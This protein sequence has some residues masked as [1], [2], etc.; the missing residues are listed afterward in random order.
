MA[1]EE[2]MRESTFPSDLKKCWYR[3]RP[4]LPLFTSSLIVIC[5]PAYLSQ[6]MPT[7][8]EM[9]DDKTMHQSIPSQGPPTP[10]HSFLPVVHRARAS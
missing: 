4:W 8:P 9:T 10:K 3:L 1:V 2:R 6:D 5:W 7:A